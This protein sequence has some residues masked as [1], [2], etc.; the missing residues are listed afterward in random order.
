MKSVVIYCKSYIGDLDRAFVLASSI[1]KYNADNIPFY[2]SVPNRDVSLFKQKLGNLATIINDEE[3]YQPNQSEGW[4]NQQIIKSSFWKLKL[5]ENYVMIDSDSYFIK[6]FNIND[7]IVEGTDNVPYTVMHEQKDLF[8][9][10]ANKK[11]MLGF[12]P[13][14]SF[15][16]CR[17]SIMDIF[18]RKG[19][20]Y[21]F[22]PSPTIWSKKVW[23]SLEE[24]YLIPNNIK[25]EDAIKTVKSEFAWYGEW[26]LTDKTISIFPIEP[27]FK[28]FHY[29]EQYIDAKNQNY[30]EEDLSKVYM[31]IV[32]QSN[33]GSPLKY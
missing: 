23:Q 24:T 14:E 16:E 8:Y 20:Y 30:S 3:I 19:R 31:G 25:F 7:F 26:L 13:M 21:D 9:W 2:V 27:L 17:Q 33:W 11:K 22:G 18:E 29:P 28:V 10:T 15:K 4:L 5:C 32:M 1:S 12:D 6:P